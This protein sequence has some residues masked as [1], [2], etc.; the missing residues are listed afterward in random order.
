MPT[1]TQAPAPA[2]P[3]TGPAV[4]GVAGQAPPPA[5][6][7]PAV[8]AFEA[9][10]VHEDGLVSALAGLQSQRDVLQTQMR[11]EPRAVRDAEA[12]QVAQVNLQ[13]AQVQG[14]LAAT[15]AQI[16]MHQGVQPGAPQARIIIPPYARGNAMNSGEVTAIVIVFTLAV[17][18]PLS[19]GIL[20]RL[21]RVTPKDTSRDVISPRLDRFEHA[22]DAIAVEVERISEGQRFVT[23]V[24][25]ERPAV[26][27]APVPI[28][29]PN[30]MREYGNESA[31]SVGEAKPFRALGAGP[32][33]PIRMQE[34]Q[35]VR[36]SITPY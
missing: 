3:A 7:T 20:R 11:H 13:I 1:I 34:R 18:M 12:P 33:E 36:P 2:A 15:R 8:A 22:I 25:A 30:P 21:W 17:L 23:K 19:I 24:L 32:I 14:E 28:S 31:S 29:V 35:A 16:A 9:L 4:P 26:A 5:G 27:P 6:A 10:R